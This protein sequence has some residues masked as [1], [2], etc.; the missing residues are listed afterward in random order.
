MRPVPSGSKSLYRCI[1]A[2][3]RNNCPLMLE[4][5]L[6]GQILFVDERQEFVCHV[7]KQRLVSQ[8]L[9]S[10]P[11]HRDGVGRHVAPRARIAVKRLTSWGTVEQ[12]NRPSES[13]TREIGS[14][15]IR[16]AA[17]LV[18]ALTQL[19]ILATAKQIHDVSTPTIGYILKCPTQVL[20]ASTR[21][22]GHGN[23]LVESRGVATMAATAS[24]FSTAGG[25]SPE[26]YFCIDTG[27]P[28]SCFLP[29]HRV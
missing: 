10:E 29:W 22:F 15:A 2:G 27:T 19:P 11:V 18:G 20:S 17:L 23:A 6:L 7:T 24:R 8:E 13:T 26:Q 9:G 5:H 12:L 3:Y 1:S 16:C 21:H 4:L 25:T 28:Y 14:A